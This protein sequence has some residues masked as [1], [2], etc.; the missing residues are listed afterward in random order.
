MLRDSLSF[1]ESDMRQMSELL[2]V[3]QEEITLLLMELEKIYERLYVKLADVEGIRY[4]E[5]EYAIPHNDALTIEQRR[6]R[7]LAKINSGV[8]ATKA[9]L[10]DLVRQV[11]GA[12]SVNIM[13][14]PEKYRFVIYVRTKVYEENMKI[15]D[16][17]VD[18]A[19]PA[20]LAYTFI[21][22]IYRKYRCGLWLG[23]IGSLKRRSTYE[24][25]TQGL[26]IDKYR[27]GLY[28]GMIEC[29]RIITEGRVDT[30]GL[31]IDQ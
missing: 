18:E 19:R 14:Y 30:D 28:F 23:M 8:S 5:E 27:C 29:K 3:E 21:N 7:V 17:A 6:A 31:H 13:E 10:E 1:L 12:D 2:E 24:I 22:T 15:A 16:A 20:H 9:M 26:K 4:W 11:L 25:D